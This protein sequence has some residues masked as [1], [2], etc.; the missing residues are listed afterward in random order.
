MKAWSRTNCVTFPNLLQGSEFLFR[1]GHKYKI[2]SH[3]TFASETLIYIIK[4]VCHEN[5]TGST[6]LTFIRRCILHP[7]QITS[8]EYRMIYFSEHI[9]R[10][11]KHLSMRLRTPTQV[12]FISLNNIIPDSIIP[13]I[14]KQ[15]KAFKKYDVHF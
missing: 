11:A 10:C 1:E 7:Q 15:G 12:R 5:N 4:W 8:L 6:R 14:F 2:K 13:G 9:V 3:T